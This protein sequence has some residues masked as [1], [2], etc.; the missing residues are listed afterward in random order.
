MAQGRPSPLPSHA[1]ALGRVPLS[2]ASEIVLPNFRRTEE[3]RMAKF[4]QYH[5]NYEKLYPGISSR[6]DI[7]AELKK[8]D[9][10]MEYIEVDLK[11]DRVRRS[12]KTETAVVLPS[13][14]RSYE[15]MREEQQ[16]QFAVD[17][18]T[19]E[20]KLIHS[21]EL[22]RLR[23]ALLKLSSEEAA[24]IHALFYEKLTERELAQRTCTPYMTIHDRKC[25]ILVKLHKL[26]KN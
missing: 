25:K 12:K 10:K 4:D 1:L 11:T 5:P 22:Q 24:L 15:Q 21:E 23:E 6:P 18:S 26:L 17:E 8:S 3:R 13:R 14:E 9:R 19:P 16:R 2:S 20:E 7:L